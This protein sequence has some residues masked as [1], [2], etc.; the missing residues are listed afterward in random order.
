M[1]IL[2]ASLLF[3]V[4][5]MAQD[6][7]TKTDLPGVEWKSA[8]PAQKQ[9]G[10]KVMRNFGCTCGCGMKV[11]QCRIEDP[12]CAQSKTLAAIA[13]TAAQQGKSEADIQNAL[14]GSDL[15]RQATMRNRILWDPVQIPIANAP[16]KGPDNAKITLVEFS[17]FQC[18]Y[19]A[20]AITHLDAILKAY[21]NDVRLVFKQ[22]PLDMHG[23]ARLAAAAGLAAHAQGKFWPMHDRM[24]A[25]YRNLSRA[26]LLAWAKELNLDMTK[27]TA[28]LDSPATMATVTRD[29]ADGEKIGVDATPTVFLNGKVYRGSLEPAAFRQVI[30][31]ELKA[32]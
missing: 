5:A 21:P 24:Y 30:D 15:V 27:F 17:D 29:A 19:C 26:N 11:A 31:A 1:R 16:S 3:P 22:F 8:T 28:D 18:P 13:V 20:K 14:T 2:A 23:Q 10:L 25:G 4:L 6:W 12:P 9:S 32:Q 7:Q